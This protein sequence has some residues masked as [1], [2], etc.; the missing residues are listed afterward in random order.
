[1]INSLFAFLAKNTQVIMVYYKS[2]IYI[3][4]LSLKIWWVREEAC[5]H[6]VIAAALEASAS[7]I[8]G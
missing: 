8:I 5:S 4:N 7:L 3:P 2:S 1:M 6:V